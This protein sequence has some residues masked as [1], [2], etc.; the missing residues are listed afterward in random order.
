ML[1]ENKHMQ[2]I[3]LV[4]DEKQILEACHSCLKTSG[5]TDI[6]AESDGRAVMPLLAS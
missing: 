6:V 2:R 1:K 4:D 5:Y 3:L